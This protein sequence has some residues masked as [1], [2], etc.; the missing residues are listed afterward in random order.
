VN[1][2]ELPLESVEPLP[3][4]VWAAAALRASGLIFGSGHW[5][6]SI[7]GKALKNRLVLKLGAH[8]SWGF[9]GVKEVTPP[10]G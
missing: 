3:N 6:C 1:R 10:Q 7:S 4:S 2:G 8:F 5:R 9:R